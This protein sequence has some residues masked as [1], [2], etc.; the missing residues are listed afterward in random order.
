MDITRLTENFDTG[1]FERDDGR[2]FVRC[3]FDPNNPIWIDVTDHTWSAVYAG[4]AHE[5]DWGE[6]N[7]PEAVT[8]PFQQV[9]LTKLT[10]TAPT[11]LRQVSHALA[12][13]RNVSISQDVDFQHGFSQ[14]DASQWISIWKRLDS[15]ARSILRSLYREMAERN[16]GGADFSLATEMGRW[17]ARQD[18]HVLRFVMDW[19]ATRGSFTSSEFEAIRSKLNLTIAGESDVDCAIRIFARILIET[20]K[21]PTQIL[22]MKQDALWI[23]PSGREFFLRIPKAKAQVAERPGLWQITEELARAVQAYS[24]RPGIHSAQ[25][26]VDRLIVLAGAK[27]MEARWMK[28]G[29]VDVVTAKIRLQHWAKR[30]GLTS[31][32]TEQL[33]NLTPYRI[34][35]TGAT[36]MAMQGVPRDQIQDVLEQDSPYAA[37]AYI[38]AVGSD[39]MPAL[40]RATDRGVGKVFT[41]FHN[42]YFFKGT[43]VDTAARRPVHIPISVESTSKPAVVGACGKSGSCKLHPFWA[44]YNGCPHFLALRDG[45]H[46]QS[47]DFVESQLKRWSNAEGGKERSKLEKDFDRIGAAIR[48]VI[49]QIEQSGDEEPDE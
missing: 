32:R 5:I 48:E 41:G 31:P 36:T 40:E 26:R 35:H 25:S 15:H 2:R 47:L 42:A 24:Q 33:I 30:Q 14:V 1:L 20:L 19:D 4:R 9:L 45:P 12:S 17:K 28:Y 22:S 11:Y 23:A 13:L 18:T 16:L 21:R 38:Q 7:L 3:D 6:I 29:Q 8:T 39:L 43:I 27:H 46:R 44:C 49:D 34:R 37:E 10:K